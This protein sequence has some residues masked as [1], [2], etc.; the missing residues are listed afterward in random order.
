MKTDEQFIH[1][2]KASMPSV[3]QAARWFHSRGYQ[4]IVQPLHIRPD[5]S[6]RLQYS[7]GGDLFVLQRVEVKHRS[8][9]FTC[10]ADYPYPT[11]IVDDA[12][13]W[14]K[15]NPKPYMHIIFSKDCQHAALIM[16]ST[17]KSWQR[18]SHFDEKSK[19]RREFYE[20][21][22]ELAIFTTIPE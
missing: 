3:W 7:D 17:C 15:A 9:Q 8:I 6:Q 20:C 4:A 13:V 14:D 2:L 1:D 16:G 18:T 21:P 10:R 5:V 22:S 12:N 11:L 19:G